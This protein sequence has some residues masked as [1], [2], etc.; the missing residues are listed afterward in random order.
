MQNKILQRFQMKFW[1]YNFLSLSEE[2]K[3]E[4]SLSNYDLA[5]SLDCGDIKRL[6]GFVN[7]FE[8]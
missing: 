4:G 3:K 7:Y 5:I 2:V 1:I 8:A 6:N